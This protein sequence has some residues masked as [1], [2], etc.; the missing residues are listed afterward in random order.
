MVFPVQHTY[1][2]LDQSVSQL[3]VGYLFQMCS[4]TVVIVVPIHD[5]CGLLDHY[6]VPIYDMCGLLDHYD[7]G[8]LRVVPCL[9]PLS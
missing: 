3:G 8:P 9:D 7:P 5:M 1:V 4:Q 6:V 2:L